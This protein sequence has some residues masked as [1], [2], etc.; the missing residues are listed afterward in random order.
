M[1]ERRKTRPAAL[2]YGDAYPLLG[3]H[4]DGSCTIA[5]PSGPYIL[6]PG[7]RRASLPLIGHNRTAGDWATITRFRRIWGWRWRC[8]LLDGDG[9]AA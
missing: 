6:A 2:W 8:W 4:D 5:T 7:W 9:D 3:E 1:Q